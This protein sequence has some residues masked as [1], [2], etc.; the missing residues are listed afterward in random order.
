MCRVSLNG[1]GTGRQ[2]FGPTGSP[3][4]L[5][6]IYKKLFFLL[7]TNTE[8]QISSDSVAGLGVP[9]WAKQTHAVCLD[10]LYH[11]LEEIEFNQPV[12]KINPKSL[13]GECCR[14]EDHSESIGP[15][16]SG[17]ATRLG[18]EEEQEQMWPRRK[19]TMFSGEESVCAK[20]PGQEQVATMSDEAKRE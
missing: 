16:W 4:C 9:W 13:C 12:T 6:N 5:I 15:G 10:G 14:A 3:A 18:S 1:R 20:V 11:L 19:L 2:M 7:S 17:I 8:V